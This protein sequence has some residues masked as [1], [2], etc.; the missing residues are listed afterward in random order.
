MLG[1]IDVILLFAI[2]CALMAPM[3]FLMKRVKSGGVR[4]RRIND[5]GKT[6]R[7]RE[8]LSGRG[9][10]ELLRSSHM[11][12][13]QYSEPLMRVE[14]LPDI[15]DGILVEDLVNAMRYVAEMW[16]CQYVVQR[17]ERVRRR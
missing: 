7:R 1:Y 10:N 5:V 6:E 8:W 11:L 9:H 12:S 17:P 4:R 13:Q 2:V 3:A 14:P 16:R 15:R